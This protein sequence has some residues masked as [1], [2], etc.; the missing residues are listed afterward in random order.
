VLTQQTLDTAKQ[1]LSNELGRAVDD[2]ECL[3]TLAEHF[4][5]TD[6]PE[7]ALGRDGRRRRRIDRSLYRVI[8]R[9]DPEDAERMQTCIDGFGW[10][11]IDGDDE[12]PVTSRVRSEMLRCDAEYVR[13]ADVG[14]AQPA[15]S[16]D[17]S[18]EGAPGAS[19]SKGNGRAANSR[20]VPPAERDVKTPRA[21]R[22]RV[23]ARDG[24]RCRACGLQRRLMVHHVHY[25][26]RGGPTDA[27]NL[28]TVC[29]PC[30]ALVHADLLKIVPGPDGELRF[31]DRDGRDVNAMNPPEA[32]ASGA[33]RLRLLPPVAAGDAQAAR[34]PLTLKGLPARVDG[35]WWRRHAACLRFGRDG[36]LELRPGALPH[37][38]ADAGEGDD[39]T[40]RGKR[41]PL[42]AACAGIVGQD[43]LL[44]RLDV[45]ARGSAGLARPFPHTLFVGPAGTGKSTLCRAI[46]ASQGARLHT[47][48]GSV[49]HD[50]RE[51]IGLLAGLRP[52]DVLFI[53][54][55]H[56]LPRR[57]QEMLYDAMAERCLHLTV[58]DASQARTITLDVPAFTLLAATTSDGSLPDP[59]LSRFGLRESLGYYEVGDLARIVSV[60]SAAKGFALG[61]EAA[62]RLALAARGTPR[63]A[64][65]LLD[66][67][68]DGA[69]AI[70]RDAIDEPTV[71]AT[72][73]RLGR[74]AYG[75]E[76]RERR[77]LDV[78]LTSG[79]PVALSRLAH[80]LGTDSPSLARQVEPHLFCRGLVRITVRGRC[81][82]AAG[83]RVLETRA[84]QGPDRDLRL[85]PNVRRMPRDRPQRE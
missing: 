74:D 77:Y 19:P 59:L 65:R 82:T 69:V 49:L 29:T 4:L 12:D 70:G 67:V 36:G 62:R 54:E 11:S 55:I 7:G 14:D 48:L 44:E 6:T 26:S 72:L 38:D 85:M 68:I 16:R 63:E 56:A 23:I 2:A 80:C 25:R 27:A 83:R 20:Q 84:A 76:G 28:A 73:A 58:R 61:A 47:A 13:I 71:E 52:G 51:L 50:P 5:A 35:A 40:A 57:L 9:L 24:R 22:E 66:R 18:S 10:V 17:R 32:C 39:A 46:A 8:V 15:G 41:Q 30:H 60:R 33:R 75:L 81:L 53:D 1:R 3:A 79:E 43:A 21:L 34:E 78:L 64:A 37:V 31:L 45:T 42:A